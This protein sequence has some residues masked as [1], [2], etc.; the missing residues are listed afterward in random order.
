MRR[1]GAG[2]GATEPEPALELTEEQ[3]SLLPA[4]AREALEEALGL[5]R[6]AARDAGWLHRRT[7][8]FVT[9]MQAA[10]RAA[11]GE[12]ALRGCIGTIRPIRTL[13]DDLRANTRAAALQDPRFPPLTSGELGRAPVT[14]S[15]SVLSPLSRLD[16][17]SEEELLAALSPGEHGV[18]LELGRLTGTYLP[19]VWRHF[20][21]REEFLASL[22]VKAGLP[23]DFWSPELVVWTF[24]V[25]SWSED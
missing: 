3:G 10:R 25:R 24:G 2:P 11:G 7:A 22:K 4:I 14:I 23:A 17:A 15:V 19:Q 20:T 21:R 9:L 16:A 18:V 1:G 6:F 13:I 8:T 12:P 5:G